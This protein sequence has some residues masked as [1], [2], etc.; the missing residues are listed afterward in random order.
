MTDTKRTSRIVGAMVVLQLI[1]LMVGFILI[2]DPLKTDYLTTAAGDAARIKAGLLVLLANC[3]L[4]I[5]ISIT[6][7]RVFR[8][9]SQPMAIWLIVLSIVMFVMQAVDGVHVMS[10]LSLSQ[11]YTESGGSPEIYNALA[12]SVRAARRWAHFLEL[13]AIDVWIMM[14]YAIIIR[15]ALVPRIFAVLCLLTV[16]VHFLA[17]PLPGFLGYGINTTLGIPMAFGLLALSVWLI[18]KGVRE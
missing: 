2:T 16:I 18:V 5:A 6:A 17:I 8:E 11:Q 13:F 12:F 10:M 7:W 3:A 4:T 9:F 1:G 14:F 15:F